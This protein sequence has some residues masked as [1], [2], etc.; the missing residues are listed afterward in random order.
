MPI[1]NDKLVQALT[2][3]YAELLG[4]REMDLDQFD[5]ELAALETVIQLFEPNW[6]PT[7]I[8]PIRRRHSYAEHGVQS[9]LI[10]E[11]IRL[12]EGAF[13][14]DEAASF[15]LARLRVDA[16]FSAPPRNN[17][18]ATAHT[19]FRRNEGKTIKSLGGRPNKWI[20]LNK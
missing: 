11:F 19:I 20:K 15:V 8:V 2:R 6:S 1:S 4:Q 13:S 3:K 10:H 9:Q 5:P 18:R 17:I 12:S 16:N 14:A 7:G